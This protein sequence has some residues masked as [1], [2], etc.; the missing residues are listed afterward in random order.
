M[1]IA[2]SE[3]IR[4]IT[5][6]VTYLFRDPP[7]VAAS[8]FL[9]SAIIP[10]LASLIGGL[11]V[12]AGVA[13]SDWRAERRSKSVSTALLVTKFNGTLEYILSARRHMETAFDK[14]PSGIL[15]SWAPVLEEFIGTRVLPEPLGHRE[16]QLLA[17]VQ[18]VDL[19]SDIKEMENIARSISEGFSKYNSLRDEFMRITA[20]FSKQKK[21]QGEMVAT[22]K[23]KYSDAPYAPRLIFICDAIMDQLYDMLI[24]DEGKMEHCF[25]S[26]AELLAHNHKTWALG[27]QVGVQ[28]Q[29]MPWSK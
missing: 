8:N 10:L 1:D 17:S 11:F 18:R 4:L 26:M 14:V 5:G 29:A 28:G 21:L 6:I 19:Y 20:P 24:V 27:V 13:Y 25:R 7:N 12:L 3:I 9:F 22:A 2:P 16:L 23:F 15:T